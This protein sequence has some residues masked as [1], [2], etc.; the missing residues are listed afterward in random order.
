MRA[1]YPKQTKLL[2]RPL[3]E[4]PVSTRTRWAIIEMISF[5]FS[6]QPTTTNECS[7]EDKEPVRQRS[8]RPLGLPTSIMPPAL[9][10]TPDRC[11]RRHHTRE[12]V[13]EGGVQKSLDIVTSTIQ[14][15]I[16]KGRRMIYL[17]CTATA[18]CLI[19]APYRAPSPYNHHP[20]G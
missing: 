15:M 16:P 6:K 4:K 8:Y 14:K 7:G 1:L 2:V 12:S 17:I 9:L 13:G 5:L 18:P 20:V 3:Y 19:P 10:Q 11:K